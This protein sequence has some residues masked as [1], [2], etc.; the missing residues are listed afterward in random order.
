MRKLN[1]PLSLVLRLKFEDKIHKQAFSE[2]YFKIF[3]SSL[4]C[5]FR[6]TSR[7]LLRVGI[8]KQL[9]LQGIA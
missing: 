9:E 3:F 1:Q 5:L 6:K 4:S 7:S 8:K 2:L